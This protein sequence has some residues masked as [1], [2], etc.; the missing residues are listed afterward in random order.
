MPPIWKDGEWYI[1]H[2]IAFGAVTIQDGTRYFYLLGS[3]R[4]QLPEPEFRQSTTF[5]IELGGLEAISN[6]DI[7]DQIN[8]GKDAD[9]FPVVARMGAGMAITLDAK[10]LMT[11]QEI[12]TLGLKPESI[13][14][15]LFVR[16]AE[17]AGAG[18]LD[19]P[20]GIVENETILPD[21]LEEGAELGLWVDG[22]WLQFD[23]NG[24]PFSFPLNSVLSNRVE[25][26]QRETWKVVDPEMECT[27]VVGVQIQDA[28]D[29]FVVHGKSIPCSIVTEPER[30]SMELILFGKV[31]NDAGFGR[32]RLQ[33]LELNKDG[34]PQRRQI[35]VVTWSNRQL[36]C[37]E[38]GPDGYHEV[39]MPERTGKAKVAIRHIIP[40]LLL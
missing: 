11:E 7:L 37:L 31:M 22:G 12:K 40:Y 13:C 16:K 4:R 39:P 18:L 38:D 17:W 36:V 24:L 14:L 21:A 32:F 23:I 28:P 10:D 25:S 35:L 34:S 15:P 27:G 1:P 6:P 5:R 8:G 2:V 9:Y 19:I 26:I 33:D 20:A 3:D 29:R 30:S